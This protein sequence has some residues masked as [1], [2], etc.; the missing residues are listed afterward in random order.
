MARDVRA[1]AQI[2][3]FDARCNREKAIEIGNRLYRLFA[4]T[5]SRMM[6]ESEIGPF[7]INP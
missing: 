1:L 3:A 4:E 2:A 7:A 6:T 5:G